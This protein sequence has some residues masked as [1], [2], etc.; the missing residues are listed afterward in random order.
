M[1]IICFEGASAVGKTA[2]SEYL[3]ENFNACVIPEVNLLFQRTPDEPKFW[4]FERQVERC[5]LAASA[6]KNY[7]I[8]I[9]DSDPFQPVWYN[10]SYG[11]DFGEPFEE[12]MDFYRRKLAAGE[13]AFP[14]KYF[15]LTVKPEELRKRK[16]S[17]ALRTRKN[18]DRHLRF[19]EP[20]TAYF[21]FIKST[22]SDLVEFIENKEIEKSAE[23]VINSIGDNFNRPGKSESLALF[24]SIKNWLSENKAENFTSSL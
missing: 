19:I 11:F 6:S 20:Q 10:W 23:K 18:F 8:V 15:I 2:L 3:R 12:I 21:N 22:N 7:E 16:T 17:D 14:D 9:L 24:D 1:P 4:Y 13:I 5:Q